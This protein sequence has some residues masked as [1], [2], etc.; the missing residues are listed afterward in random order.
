MDAEG[1]SAAKISVWCGELG[2]P[3]PPQSRTD[4]GQLRRRARTCV[5]LTSIHGIWA[6]P[7]ARAFVTLTAC[8]SHTSI[9]SKIL[10]VRG[11]WIV[12]SGTYR[13]PPIPSRRS[14]LLAMVQIRSYSTA[15]WRF[16]RQEGGALRGRNQPSVEFATAEATREGTP[17]V[18]GGTSRRKSQPWCVTFSISLPGPPGAGALRIR[19]SATSPSNK[20]G[21]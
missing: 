2:S 17:G 9:S 3:G 18:L 1:L 11:Q 5:A 4:S 8:E 20:R 6:I 14:R 21:S 19:K 15:R 13:C 10:Q 7:S 16:G 12:R